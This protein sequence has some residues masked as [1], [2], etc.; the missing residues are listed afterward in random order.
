M[1]NAKIII[2]YYCYNGEKI[3]KIVFPISIM[4]LSVFFIRHEIISHKIPLAH[5]VFLKA[6]M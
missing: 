5:I 6:M 3:N 4:L 1:N 2:T